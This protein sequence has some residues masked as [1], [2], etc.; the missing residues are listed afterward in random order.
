MQMT[1]EYILLFLFLIIADTLAV[2]TA[3]KSA[4]VTM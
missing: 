1:C 3:H 4:L 2:T